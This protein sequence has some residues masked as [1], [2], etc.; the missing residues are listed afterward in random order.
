MGKELFNQPTKSTL[1]STDRIAT[2]VPSQEGGDNIEYQDLR[3]QIGDEIIPNATEK[4]TPVDAD[5]IGLSDSADSNLLKWL[6]F[7]NLKAFLKTYF[8][9]LYGS[10]GGLAISEN[11]GTEYTESVLNIN[12]ANSENVLTNNSGVQNDYSPKLR[13]ATDYDATGEAAGDIIQRNAT[14]DGYEP[15]ATA[16]FEDIQRSSEAN[17]SADGQ[18]S[19]IIPAGYKIDTIILKETAGNAAGNISLGTASLGA[20]IVSA[21]TVGGSAVVDAT[22]VAEFFSDVNDTDIYI[23]SSAWGTGVLTVY[24][25][26]KKVV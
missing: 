11:D 18:L 3:K 6:S 25:T 10:G 1:G 14:N 4:T 2:G 15:G 23:S 13:A 7:T 9:T 22:L 17:I 12:A 19:T 26:F 21:E 24:F 16:V 8:D 5:K 20:Q